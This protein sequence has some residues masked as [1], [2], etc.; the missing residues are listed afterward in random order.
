MSQAKRK[1]QL[2]LLPLLYSS[3]KLEFLAMKWAIT[4][5][6][7]HYFLG[8]HFTVITDN[9]STCFPSAKLG[10]LEQR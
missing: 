10:P 6:F 4:E 9:P 2:L 1:E 5:T 3:M 8:G 7:R